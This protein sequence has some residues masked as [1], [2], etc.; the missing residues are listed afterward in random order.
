MKLA[1]KILSQVK[2]HEADSVFKEVEGESDKEYHARLVKARKEWEKDLKKYEI[3]KKGKLSWWGGSSPDDA[4]PFTFS[5]WSEDD[6]WLPIEPIPFFADP[7]KAQAAL[8]A[9]LKK[10]GK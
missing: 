4:K 9:Y 5:I 8:K 7:K 2:I 6:G 3:P 1:E 10:S